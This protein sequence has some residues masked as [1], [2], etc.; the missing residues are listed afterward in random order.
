[1]TRTRQ[2]AA[3][4]YLLAF[5]ILSFLGEYVAESLR[6][7]KYL[8]PFIALCA[9]IDAPRSGPGFEVQNAVFRPLLGVLAGGLMVCLFLAAVQQSVTMRFVSEAYFLLGPL[10]AQALVFSFAAPERTDGYVRAL[11]VGVLTAYLLE[12]HN[13]ILEILGSPSTILLKFITSD[14]SSESGT[15]FAFGLF[16]LY[17]AFARRTWLA[18]AS[19]AFVVLSYKR[20]AIAGTFAI[21]AAFYI[22]R[23]LGL[24]ITRWRRWIPLAMVLVN[25]LILLLTYKLSEGTFDDAIEDYTG[26][27]SNWATQGRL[28]VYEMAIREG[29]GFSLLGRGLGSVTNLLATLGVEVGNAHSDILKYVLELGPIISSVLL[30]KFYELSSRT[31]EMFLLT[32]YVNVLFVTDNV[33]IYFD[34]MFIFYTL[35]GCLAIR[36]RAV[37]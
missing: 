6:Y 23:A 4:A 1:M 13:E 34:F 16:C 22:Q 32:V 25:V 18:V 17:F 10:V 37:R 33:S 9:A 27:S 7:M 30:W 28:G 19:L 35:L 5:F 14:A 26:I 12:R 24:E 11:F 8:V 21:A 36:G 29:G 31:V 20:I 3:Y 15:S 2:S